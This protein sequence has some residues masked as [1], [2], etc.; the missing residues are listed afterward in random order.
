M[1]T[2]QQN[3]FDDEEFMY[4]LWEVTLLRYLKIQHLHQ[5]VMSN[6]DQN[7]DIDFVER[8]ALVFAELLQYLEDKCRPLVIWD[9]WDNER[10][11]L[12]ILTNNMCQK[13]RLEVIYFYTEQTF[14]RRLESESITDY[15]IKTENISN[16]QKEAWEVISD[17]LLI[18]MVLKDLPPNFK[19]FK[20]VITKKKNLF[21]F[22][23]FKVCLRG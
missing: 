15:I 3:P 4:E 14:L 10:K 16:A 21:F 20:T 2:E 8:N 1:N 12:P 5:I 17:E 9:A 22:S 6:T 23:V 19:P 18:A 11:S 7:D 13:G